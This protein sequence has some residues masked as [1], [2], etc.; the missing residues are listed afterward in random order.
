MKTLSP[1]LDTEDLEPVW[2]M[3]CELECWQRT[4]QTVEVSLRAVDFGTGWPVAEVDLEERRIINM[5][6]MFRGFSF[7]RLDLDSLRPVDL[8]L[9]REGH[10][11]DAL[12]NIIPRPATS[13]AEA[14]GG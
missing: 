8:K 11:T 12:W 9:L 3:R 5:S 4:S 7:P 1:W 14:F 6:Y 10:L 13:I 2:I